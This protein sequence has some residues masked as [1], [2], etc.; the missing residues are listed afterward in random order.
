M[1]YF[2]SLMCC[3][4]LVCALPASAEI[5]KWI[6][7]SGNV[8]YSQTP[9][10]DRSAEK[11]KGA[12]KPATGSEQTGERLDAQLKESDERKAAEGKSE[13]ELAIEAENKRIAVENC[14]KAT[15]N[16]ETLKSRGQISIKEEDGSFRKLAEEERQARIS[17][18]Q[19]QVE[20]FCN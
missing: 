7:A 11:V 6:D 4:L 2:K 3:A 13:E 5:Y 10:P 18:A 19:A 14:K 1:A 9:P 8:V 16:S 17:E 15:K 20:E 12:T